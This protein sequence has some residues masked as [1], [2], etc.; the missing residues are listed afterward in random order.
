MN[1]ERARASRRSLAHWDLLAPA[2][3]P[4]W[5]LPQLARELDVAAIG[6]KDES[7]RSPLG[8]FKVLGAPVALLRLIQRRCPHLSDEALLAGLHAGEL[9][10]LVAISAT[11]GNHGRALAAAARSV[12]CRCVI[13]LHAQV[14]A[15]REQAQTPQEFESFRTNPQERS[16]ARTA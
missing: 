5:A 16:P 4:V 6:V 15:E 10:D 13:V 8:S 2:P 9:Q 7:A 12:G 11:D 1:I 14:S 3:T